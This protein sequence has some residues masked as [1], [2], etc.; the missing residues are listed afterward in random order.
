[1][2]LFHLKSGT[3]FSC[4]NEIKVIA[5]LLAV[6]V[7]SLS[8]FLSSWIQGEL[9]VECEAVLADLELTRLYNNI[10]LSHLFIQIYLSLKDNLLS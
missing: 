1:M 6:R 8:N 10:L 4:M 3:V 5:P 7:V 2:L 9:Y